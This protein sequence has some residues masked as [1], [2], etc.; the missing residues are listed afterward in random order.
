MR[1]VDPSIVGSGKSKVHR[2]DW[3]VGSLGGISTFKVL[4]QKSL[5]LR[6]LQF[7]FL[8]PSVDWMLGCRPL[9][10]GRGQEDSPVLKVY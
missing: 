1:S 9:V 4:R 2:A 3:Q 10:L 7:L 5:S 8:R 6:K